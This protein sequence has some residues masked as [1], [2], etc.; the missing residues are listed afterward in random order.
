MSRTFI[1]ATLAATVVA[2]PVGFLLYGVLFAELFAEGAITITGVMREQPDIAWIL[3]GQLPFAALVTLVVQWRGDTSFLGGARSGATLGLL[4][5]V[6]YDFAQYGTTHLW[7][8]TATLVD[9]L[10]SAVLVSTAGGVAAMVLQRGGTEV[11]EPGE[12]A[13]SH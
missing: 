7:T 12:P 5:A 13:S 10:I 8:L 4:M 6:G 2:L 3:L 1:A 9:P 11:R